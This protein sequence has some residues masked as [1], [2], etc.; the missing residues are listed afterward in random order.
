MEDQTCKNLQA[1]QQTLA[2][3]TGPEGCPWDKAQTPLSLADYLIEESHE[4]AAAIRSGH[5]SEVRG[6]MGDLLFL[7]VFIAALFQ[8][9]GEFTLSDALAEVNAKMIRRHPHVFGATHFAN[10]D[11]QL[12]EWERIKKREKEEQAPAK[13]SQGLYSSLPESLPPLIKAYR[14]HSK[15]ARAGFTWPEDEEAERQVE[16]EWLEWLDASQDKEETAMFHEFGDILFSLV[17]VG[18]RKGI[19]AT[20]ALDQACRRFLARY[21]R[22]EELAMAKGLDLASLPL[23]EQD[24]LWIQVKEEEMPVNKK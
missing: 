1:L 3:L 5:A 9:K 22:M 7:I 2:H 13:T 24:E 20:D 15:A 12:K 4:L 14:I 8:N 18:R 17:E 23:D 16:S 6:E 11:E 10:L 19:K 21:A